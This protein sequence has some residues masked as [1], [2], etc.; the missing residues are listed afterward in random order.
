[1]TPPT[2]PTP[3]DLTA[4]AFDELRGYRRSL[5]SEEDRVS[6]W[7]RL[8]HARMDLLTAQ[9]QSEVPLTVEDLVRVLGDTGSGRTRKVLLRIQAAAPLPELPEVAEIWSDDVDP[10]DDGAVTEALGRLQDAE[11][12]LTAYRRALHE[13]IGAATEHLIERYRDNPS[14]ALSLIPME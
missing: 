13:R 2:P 10:H 6:Y 3:V 12:Q 8:V 1:M 9:A 11:Q 4:L 5:E 7:R 14:A